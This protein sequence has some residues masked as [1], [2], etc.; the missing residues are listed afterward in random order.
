MVFVMGP[1]TCC[2]TVAT[3]LSQWSSAECFCDGVVETLLVA[4]R[5]DFMV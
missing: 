5:C 3:A 4:R 1:W 2:P